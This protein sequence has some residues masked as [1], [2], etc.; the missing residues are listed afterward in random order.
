MD[1]LL[2]LSQTI[3]GE[4][5]GLF[6]LTIGLLT[7]RLPSVKAIL[8]DYRDQRW[9]WRQH[10]SEVS[11]VSSRFNL[12]RLALFSVAILLAI[13]CV[14]VILRVVSL[15]DFLL[16]N[17][18]YL[19]SIIGELTINELIIEKA[20]TLL[21]SKTIVVFLVID[22]MILLFFQVFEKSTKDELTALEQD[23]LIHEYI[24]DGVEGATVQSIWLCRNE[25][26]NKSNNAAVDPT[27]NWLLW[28]ELVHNYRNKRV[29]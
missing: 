22:F 19:G 23:A 15:N 27:E 12:I 29:S 16:E 21:L 7:F 11:L 8:K 13:Y 26:V 28:C 10:L 6:A 14:F 2:K 4:S 3:L 1:E 25:L 9:R 5:F 24:R 18:D 20:R 17:S